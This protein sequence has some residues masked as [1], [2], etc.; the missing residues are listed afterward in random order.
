[1][2]RKIR[3]LLQ[4]AKYTII[5]ACAA[6]VLSGCKTRMIDYT[7]ISSKNVDISKIKTFKHG[8]DRAVGQDITYVILFIPTGTPNLKE[9]LDRAIQ[10]VPGAVALVDGVVYV[11]SGYFLLGGYSG[12]TVEGTALI[13]PSLPG[14]RQSMKSNYIIGG[15]NR[16]QRAYEYEFVD[17][18]TYKAAKQ[19][20]QSNRSKQIPM[21]IGQKSI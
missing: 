6:L 19:H 9:A 16:D 7:I 11:E 3:T 2:K 4:A 18:A 15:Y 17:E 5:L 14:A 20:F 8:T 1:M 12:F 21:I 13:D 10:G